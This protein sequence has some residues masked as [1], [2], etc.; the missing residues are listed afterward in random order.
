MYFALLHR[1]FHNYP[2]IQQGVI[3]ETI[4]SCGAMTV[5]M[6]MEGKINENIN[7]VNLFPH[8]MKYVS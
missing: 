7:H 2:A 3:Q 8:F 6:C 5:S 4:L 1:K